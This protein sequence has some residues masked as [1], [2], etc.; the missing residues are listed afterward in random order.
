MVDAVLVPTMPINQ[1]AATGM[2]SVR[3]SARPGSHTAYMREPGELVVEWYDFGDHA[4]YESA[5]LIIFDPSAQTELRRALGLSPHGN[6]DDLLA[7]LPSR[8]ASYFEVKK[9]AAGHAIAFRAETDFQ[10]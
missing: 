1:Q 10:P 8:F 4:P 9:F 7:Q 2:Q 5:N 3:F 6:S